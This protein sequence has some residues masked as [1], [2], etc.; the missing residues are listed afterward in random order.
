ML[1]YNNFSLEL[2]P[3]D[4]ASG[5][6]VIFVE[7]IVPFLTTPTFSKSCS[8]LSFSEMYLMLTFPGNLKATLTEKSLY[9][10]H[11]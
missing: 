1:R 5:V 11:F 10:N 4:I 6:A 8:V 2:S 7:K 9:F 3:V